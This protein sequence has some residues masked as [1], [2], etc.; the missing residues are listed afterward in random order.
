MVNAIWTDHYDTPSTNYSLHH[1]I[2]G[3]PACCRCLLLSWLHPLFSINTGWTCIPLEHCRPRMGAGHAFPPH[4]P[5]QIVCRPAYDIIPR[6]FYVYMG[7]GGWQTHASDTPSGPQL[8][9]QCDEGPSIQNEKQLIHRQSHRSVDSFQDRCWV[10]GLH[11]WY[12]HPIRQHWRWICHIYWCRGFH[13]VAVVGVIC[14]LP[15]KDTGHQ[16]RIVTLSR[17]W[18]SFY[19]DIHSLCSLLYNILL[20]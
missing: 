18:Q 11:W 14:F 15:S 12:F 5:S 8:A 6:W 4:S 7:L 3:Q 17:V 10:M 1:S 19:A 2:R 16:Y 13:S 20:P 9:A